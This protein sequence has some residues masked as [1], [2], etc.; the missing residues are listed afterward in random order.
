MRSIEGVQSN[1]RWLGPARLLALIFMV[2]NLTIFIAG[3][4]IILPYATRHPNEFTAY[5]WTPDQMNHILSRIGMSIEWWIG[6]QWITS[7]IGG[8]IFFILAAL[9]L[10][11]KN[12]DWFGIYVS[13]TFVLFAG[14]VSGY[15]NAFAAEHPELLKILTPLGVLA[16]PMFFVMFYLFPDG[17]FRP[18]WT[19]WAT[20]AMALV[21]GIVFFVYS[22]NQPPV[23]YIL[24]ILVLLL[25]GVGSQIYRFRKVSNPLERQQTK[26]VVLAI[27][28][29]AGT[30]VL[31]LI[32]LTMPRMVDPNSP[33]ALLLISISALSSIVIILV[34]LSIGFAILRYRLWDVD[35]IIRRTLV[36]GAL[37]ASLATIFFGG[38]ALLQQ[39]FGRLTG[40]GNS[41]VAIVIS[42]LAIAAL[43]NPLRINIQKS[44]DR[45]FYRRK[46]NA[47]QILEIFARSAR[48]E[49]DLDN[50]TAE[51]VRVANETMQPELV[52]LWLRPSSDR[53][54]RT[55]T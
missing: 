37:T 27:I 47:Q 18:R 4:I 50:L 30:L 20:V 6:Y 40:V 48:N 36:Y 41:P 11:R 21:F 39:V 35:I 51:L 16:W 7:L 42:T 38:V 49:T 54:V 32:P 19:R 9:I 31:A 2:I 26:W 10:V 55:K 3:A 28:L 22:G 33:M 24:V 17:H 45:G 14:A 34:P 8:A 12:T 13:I 5:S 1:N 15:G 25:I 53:S 44:I 43:F 29:W 46:Y 52:S 23:L